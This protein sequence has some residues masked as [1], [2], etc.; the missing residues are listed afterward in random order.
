MRRLPAAA[1][2]KFGERGVVD[3]I[4]V[5]GYYNLVSALLNV[6]RYPLPQGASAELKPLR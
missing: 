2:A 5:I 3:M 6:D 4:S 1:K